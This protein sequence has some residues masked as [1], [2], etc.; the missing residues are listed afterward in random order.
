MYIN[1]KTITKNEYHNK[2][3]CQNVRKKNTKN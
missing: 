1:N 2:K 3:T